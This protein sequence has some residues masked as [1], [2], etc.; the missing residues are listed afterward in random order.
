M[1]G[2]GDREHDLVFVGIG[3]LEE[4]IASILTT[5]TTGRGAPCGSLTW[6]SSFNEGKFS[7]LLLSPIN[8]GCFGYIRG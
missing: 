5:S 1:R 2:M 7:F 6:T 4:A 8:V 3:K